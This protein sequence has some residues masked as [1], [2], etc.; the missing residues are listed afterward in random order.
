L[1]NLSFPQIVESEK[2]SEEMSHQIF[3]SLRFA[4]AGNEANDLKR[5]LEERGVSTFLCA[6]QPGGDIRGEIVNA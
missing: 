6:V 5:V 4:E 1:Q 2:N 3:I